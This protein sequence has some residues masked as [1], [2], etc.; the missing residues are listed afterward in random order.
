MYDFPTAHQLARVA[1]QLYEQGKPVGVAAVCHGPA[2]FEATRTAAGDSIAKGRRI[3]GFA[4]P[5]EQQMGWLEKMEADGV[6][7][8]ESIAQHVEAV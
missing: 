2:I 7:T 3:T 5:G 4:R 6:G 1:V 8:C